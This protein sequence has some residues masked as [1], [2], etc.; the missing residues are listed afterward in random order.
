V[1]G[2]NPINQT[3]RRQETA[4]HES[5]EVSP[6]GFGHKATSCEKRDPGTRTQVT[7]G[8]AGASPQTSMAPLR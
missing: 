5:S 4:P 2:D 3:V 6:C 7:Q 1:V 8:A